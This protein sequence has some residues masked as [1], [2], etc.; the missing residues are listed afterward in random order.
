MGQGNAFFWVL[1][2]IRIEQ[3]SINSPINLESWY[4]LIP[5]DESGPAHLSG[6]GPIAPSSLKHN[7]KLLK[8]RTYRKMMQIENKL[9]L[10]WII[11]ILWTSKTNWSANVKVHKSESTRYAHQSSRSPK[12][13]YSQP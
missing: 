13:R 5:N 9:N 6:K 8:Y 1:W 12:P 10:T 2:T 4:H 11:C 7:Q 3:H